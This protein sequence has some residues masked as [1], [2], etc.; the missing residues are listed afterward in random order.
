MESGR[1]HDPAERN[2]GTEPASPPPPPP[3][4]QPIVLQLP[5]TG[6][7][8]QVVYVQQTAPKTNG[9]AI[10]SMVLG[11]IWIYW[12]GSILALVFGYI[13]RGQIR[14]SQGAQSGDGM[15]IAGIVL[16]WIGVGILLL[17]IVLGVG[18]GV[19]G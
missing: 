8:P 11:I 14:R 16:G 19:A 10:A 4:Q 1:P 7:V 9:F 6:A 15:A 12:I 2:E 3:D 5:A 17:L 18:I 13:A